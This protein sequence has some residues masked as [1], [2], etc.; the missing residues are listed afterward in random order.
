MDGFWIYNIVTIAIGAVF[1]ILG[2]LEN[3][4]MR[5]LLGD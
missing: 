2:F 3:R 1:W 5:K 4:K